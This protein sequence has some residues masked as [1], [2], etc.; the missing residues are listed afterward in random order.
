[1]TSKHMSDESVAKALGWRRRRDWKNAW[2]KPSGK[3]PGFAHTKVPP[4][5]TSLD[6]IVAETEARGKNCKSW[7]LRW[8]EEEML[9]PW[10]PLA[11]CQAL[12]AYLKEPK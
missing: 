7:C 6:A 5:T 2:V 8:I 9:D 4:Y 12:L 1:M 10:H 3:R 11:C